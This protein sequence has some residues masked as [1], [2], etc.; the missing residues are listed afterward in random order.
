MM[1]ITPTVK[2]LLILNVL[3]YIGSQIVGEPAYE[4][5]SM[6]FPANPKFEYWQIITHMFMHAPMPNFS[7]ILFNMFALYSFGS[8]LEHFWGSKKFLFFYISCGLGSALLHNLVNY[9]EYHRYDYVPSRDSL[10]ANIEAQILDKPSATPINADNRLFQTTTNDKDAMLDEWNRRMKLDDQ[11]YRAAHPVRLKMLNA[12]DSKDP[13][14]AQWNIISG[15]DGCAQSIRHKIVSQGSELWWMKATVDSDYKNDDPFIEQT[16]NSFKPNSDSAKNQVYSRKF[17]RFVGDIESG[18]DSIRASAVEN[19]YR[20]Q[21]DASELPELEKFLSRFNPSSSETAAVIW[22]IQ[23]AGELKTERV[24]DMFKTLYLGKSAT[25]RLQLSILKALADKREKKAYELIA[26]LMESDLPVSDDAFSIDA[27]FTKFASDPKNSKELYPDVFTYFGIPEYQAPVLEFTSA[28]IKSKEA[29][30]HKIRKYRKLLLG[31]ARLEFKRVS[32]ANPDLQREADSILDASQSTGKLLSYLRLLYPYK[33][34]K[35]IAQFFRAC[36][37][38]NNT[39]I[40][41][42]LASLQLDYGPMPST[43]EMKALLSNKATQY[44]AYLMF[45][46]ADLISPDMV[47]P[48]KDLARA[49]ITAEMSDSPKL[50]V[51]YID[52][53]TIS[54]AGSTCNVH[55]FKVTTNLEDP[56]LEFSGMGT[57]SFLAGFSFA[58]M[59]QEFDPSVYRFSVLPYPLNAEDVAEQC[60]ALA[61]SFLNSRHIRATFD[62]A[63]PTL[64]TGEII[65][66]E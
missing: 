3:F 4:L 52:Q 13:D 17:S 41:V 29:A 50:V 5:L 18:V 66:E 28:L 30:P 16:F 37:S 55:F 38:L 20:M 63:Q 32:G 19:V 44:A 7:H 27:L 31:S 61:D 43:A 26:S 39:A 22:L 46:K 8:A 47:I 12:H 45:S 14:Y 57:N 36:Q 6:Y 51:E 15:C 21:I 59:G 53:R 25:S 48:E 11:T 35:K 65:E 56:D 54:N 1:Q 10:W 2:Q 9:W 60:N 24:Y 33:K 42:E 34:D 58:P 62:K 64:E 23:R 49:A 40:S